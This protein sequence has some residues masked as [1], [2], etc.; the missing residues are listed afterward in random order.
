MSFRDISCPKC[1]GTLPGEARKRIVT[2]TYCGA[3]VMHEMNVVHASS[4]RNAFEDR[5]KEAKKSADCVVAEV[6]YRIEGRLGV[7]ESS[8]VFLATRCTSFPERVV[9]KVLRNKVDQ[10]LFQR[11]YYL[12]KELSTN[13]GKG[14]E[15][16]SRMIPIPVHEG[17][18]VGNHFPVGSKAQVFLYRPGFTHTL[19]ALAPM[20]RAGDP[21]HAI[22]MARRILEVLGWVHAG[23][24]V[25]GAI[26]PSNIVIHP[27]DHGALLVGFG[28]A[29]L[30]GANETA[31]SMRAPTLYPG[32]VGSALDP[33]FDL[34]MTARMMLSLF[35]H[36]DIPARIRTYFEEVG[37]TKNLRD[38]AEM[39]R[40]LGELAKEAFGPPTF[41]PFVVA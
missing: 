34:R 3:N 7:G 39:H 9:I 11:S 6:P 24:V 15:H 28:A 21:R 5:A 30:R 35:S 19:E 16:F 32:E 12:V 29:G 23:G 13:G 2:C 8:D 31:R 17:P 14:S 36:A 41:V 37:T 10:D 1:G 26:L 25:H 40:T 4:Y 33:M 20:L 22:W 27:R 18:I 38:A